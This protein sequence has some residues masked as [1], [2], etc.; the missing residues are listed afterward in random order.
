MMA[1]RRRA[2]FCPFLWKEPEYPVK[3]AGEDFDCMIGDTRTSWAFLQGYLIKQ[4]ERD[5]PYGDME[6]VFQEKGLGTIFRILRR[7]IMNFTDIDNAQRP[8]SLYQ[9]N[10]FMK[11]MRYRKLFKEQLIISGKKRNV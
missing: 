4:L 10:I 6:R 8:E 7:E 1:R 11:R 2:S 3:S 9:H 5:D